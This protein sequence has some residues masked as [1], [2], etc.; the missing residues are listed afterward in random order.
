MPLIRALIRIPLF[1]L[2]CLV[3]VPVQI[4]FLLFAKGQGIYFLP[5]IFHKLL[6]KVTGIRV[7]VEG[8]LEEGQTVF[9]CN[10]ISYLDIPVLGSQ[11]QASF[12]AKKEVKSWPLFGLLADL[13]KTVFI[14]R[15]RH[16]AASEKEKIL[17]RLKKGHSLILF[18]EATSSDGSD[19]IPFRSSFFSILNEPDI[20]IQPVSIVIEEIEG[21]KPATQEERDRYA[22]YADMEMPPHLWRIFQTKNLHVKLVFH[23][24]LSG[25]MLETDR[26][27]L[28]KTCYEQVRT[29]VKE[30]ISL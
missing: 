15:N 26:K 14:S 6:C 8:Q 13:Q 5:Q 11:I 21:K 3:C 30:S 25:K 2:L 12:I 18:P 9:V 23:P 24:P 28:A 1:L 29:P 4:L 16:D 27:T 19:V 17:I 22:W 10:H 7:S 20:K